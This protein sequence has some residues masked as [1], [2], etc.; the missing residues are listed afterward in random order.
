MAFP[1]SLL[2]QTALLS[3]LHITS[4]SVYDK[5]ASRNTSNASNE[6][7]TSL[8]E[9]ISEI[10]AADAQNPAWFEIA[11][12][13]M[14]ENASHLMS[15]SAN[16]AAHGSGQRFYAEVCAALNC[17]RRLPLSNVHNFGEA[18]VGKS[19][20]TCVVA[21]RGT[22]NLPDVIQDT[23]SYHLVPFGCSGCRVGA[24]FVSGYES[25]AGQ[26]KG[27]LHSL[28]CHSVAVTGH[29]LGAAKAILGMYE[30]AK[31]GFHIDTSYVF[32]E[33]R[34]ANG[35]FH[36]S[37]HSVV[38]APVFRV[39]HGKDPIVALGGPGASAVGSEIYEAGNSPLTDHLH[40]AGVSMTTCMP[41]GVPGGAAAER[42]GEEAAHAA[43]HVAH[44]VPGGEQVVHAA[45]SA[46]ECCMRMKWSCCFPR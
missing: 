35:A 29:S 15:M 2:V 27:A 14:D 43:E 32:G 20:G 39:V 46:A 21:F 12:V 18:A 5:V 3:L 28:G 25:V 22:A 40:Y 23:S 9:G 7:G 30:L 8:L 6:S 13:S 38:H 37:F 36:G 17:H 11:N 10:G 4:G 1:G 26:I 45:E 24:G 33:P 42:A 41:D 16:E 34:M 19:G 44:E 31:S